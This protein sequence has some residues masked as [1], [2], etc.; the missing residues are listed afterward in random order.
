MRG[1]IPALAASLCLL[2]AGARAQT[3]TYLIHFDGSCLGMTL[4]VTNGFNI[5]GNSVGCGETKR[6]YV[7]KMKE[8]EVA[9]VNNVNSA[10]DLVKLNYVI[11]M[12]KHSWVLYET[13]DGQ[14]EEIGNGFWTKRGPEVTVESAPVPPN[15]AAPSPAPPKP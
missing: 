3:R 1:A 11:S 15:A 4:H 14:T 6:A 7:G 2:G 12:R 8:G 10:E 13:L 5:K 9:D